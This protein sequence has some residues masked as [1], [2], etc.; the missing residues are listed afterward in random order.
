MS[1]KLKV[2]WMCTQCTVVFTRIH[3]LTKTDRLSG[4]SDN[5]CPVCEKTTPWSI[6]SV[7]FLD[8]SSGDQMKEEVP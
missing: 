1:A 7:S 4:D 3:R 2:N 6:H 5:S 8:A